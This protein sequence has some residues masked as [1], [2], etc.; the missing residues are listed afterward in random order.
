MM[1]NHPARFFVWYSSVAATLW[2]RISSSAERRSS[3]HYS[4][5]IC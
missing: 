5:K 1:L 3:A 4:L 2:K